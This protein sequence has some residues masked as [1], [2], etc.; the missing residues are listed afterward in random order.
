M[1]RSFLVRVEQGSL[2]TVSLTT[3]ERLA[4]GFGVNPA[5]LLSAPRRKRLALHEDALSRVVASVVVS[6]R[7]LANLTQEEL[8]VTAAVGRSHLAEIE[9]GEQNVSLDVLSRLADAL[10]C[11]LT[12]LL[13]HDELL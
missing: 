10:G 5:T 3:V 11:P 13:V 8:A 2:R 12:S 1:S 6:R 9:T 7:L 4:K